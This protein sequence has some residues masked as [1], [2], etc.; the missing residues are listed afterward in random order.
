MDGGIAIEEDCAVAVRIDLHDALRCVDGDEGVT[1]QRHRRL[2]VPVENEKAE[3]TGM[4]AGDDS[5]R[6]N[7]D[8]DR[9]DSHDPKELGRNGGAHAGGKA[10]VLIFYEAWRRRRAPFGGKVC[11]EDIVC[12]GH[13]IRR[14]VADAGEDT[15]VERAPE[16]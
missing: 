15:G 6:L 4:G 16:S 14:P 9:R 5:P 11:S 7:A 2:G 10:A 13:P 8:G 3:L 12:H 1:R